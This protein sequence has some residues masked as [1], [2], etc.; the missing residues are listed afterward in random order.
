MYFGSGA[1]LES[2]EAITL[3]KVVKFV[4]ILPPI[5]FNSYKI[6]IS[7]SSQNKI[8]YN[9]YIIATFLYCIFIFFV[10]KNGF[11]GS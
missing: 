11:L 2:F 10:I 9:S 1:G 3:G 6:K 4:I 8:I 7:Y 5:L